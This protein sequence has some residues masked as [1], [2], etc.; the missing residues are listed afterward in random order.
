LIPI[1]LL[2]VGICSGLTALFLHQQLAE[3]GFVPTVYAGFAFVIG[4]SL[5]I[6]AMQLAYRS[7]LRFIWPTSST[8]PLMTESFSMAACILFLPYLAQIEVNWPH[9]AM[10]R[11]EPAVYFAAFLLVHLILKGI[12]FFALLRSWPGTRY[13]VAGWML[14]TGF[15]VVGSFAALN[16]WANSVEAAK[17]LAPT[18]LELYR[19]GNLRLEGRFMR[20][21]AI[22]ESELTVRPT[23]S[24]LLLWSSAPADRKAPSPDR[25]FVTVRFTGSESHRVEQ[26]VD[27]APD[28]WVTMLVAAED[29]PEG[30]TACSVSWHA[31]DVPSWRTIPGLE[32][33]TKS[34]LALLMSEPLA[35]ASQDDGDAPSVVLI[36]IDGL[37]AKHMQ[38]F[39]Y[40]RET[41]PN[42]LEFGKRALRYPLAYSVSPNPEAA[43]ASILTGRDP[44]RHGYYGSEAETFD[45]AF[46]TISEALSNR[47]YFTLALTEGA[48]DGHFDYESGFDRSIDQFDD[49]FINHSANES[50]T[51]AGGSASTIWK[52]EDWIRH[53]AGVKFFLWLR[54][55][56]LQDPQIRP[57][58]ST[59]FLPE[60]GVPNADD[61][62]DTVL[63]YVD[64]HLGELLRNVTNSNLRNDICV[65]VTSSYGRILGDD[66]ATN[67]LTE[68]AL[69]VPLMIYKSGIGRG[70]REKFV[71]QDDLGVTLA[72]ITGVDLGEGITGRNLLA[73]PKSAAPISILPNPLRLSARGQRF[74]L[75]WDT[76]N[77]NLST[78]VT[79]YTLGGDQPMSSPVRR[80]PYTVQRIMSPME[81]YLDAPLERGLVPVN[82]PQE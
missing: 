32:P 24:L 40:E 8:W 6:A 11:V 44:M 74:R 54:I 80:N 17:P 57:G 4:A 53:Y 22:F 41:T 9:P 3:Q 42:L 1:Y 66:T 55:T 68:S 58:Y 76:E 30:T 59:E 61:T 69:H 52:A 56:D 49:G 51:V 64:H 2:A 67:G 12:S 36:T 15:C 21:G 75:I 78:G 27:I 35:R 70:E 77:E 50:N 31:E 14:L 62:Y 81:K 48:R 5:A 73:E 10:D 7:L 23:D 46:Q 13:G 18:D 38:S 72:A 45:S 39:G 60:N 65:V 20:E 19:A 63:Q 47:G 79:M 82:L 26:V 43:V 34:N 16:V 28:T 29:I 33:V 71:Q 37:S 25:A